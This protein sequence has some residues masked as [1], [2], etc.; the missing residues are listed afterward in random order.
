MIDKTTNMSDFTY[1]DNIIKN[2]KKFNIDD[3]KNIFKILSEKYDITNASAKEF[4]DIAKNLL[5]TQ[6]ISELDYTLMTFDTNKDLNS[7]IKRN[8]IEQLK[9]SAQK[10]L[11]AGDKNF[12]E[13][14]IK[15]INILKKIESYM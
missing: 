14:K 13:V 15:Q 6:K 4:D 7:D 3:S 8:W 11:Y 1:L 12:Y 2:N 10:S 5:E 9:I